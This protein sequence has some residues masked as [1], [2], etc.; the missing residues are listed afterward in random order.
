MSTMIQRQEVGGQETK[1]EQIMCKVREHKCNTN[2]NAQFKYTQLNGLNP[3][4]D[5]QNE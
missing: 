5:L 3:K 2:S 1:D 4:Q